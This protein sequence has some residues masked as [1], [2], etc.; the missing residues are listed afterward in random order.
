[1]DNENQ[2]EIRTNQK[3][4]KKNQTKMQRGTGALSDF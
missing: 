3:S 4:N 1:M 2:N